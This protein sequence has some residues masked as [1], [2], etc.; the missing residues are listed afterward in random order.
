MHCFDHVDLTIVAIIKRT[1]SSV[2]TFYV[3]LILILLFLTIILILIF[4]GKVLIIGGG[5][6]NFTNVAATF[7]VS[8]AVY[9]QLFN[10]WLLISNMFWNL[11]YPNAGWPVTTLWKKIFEFQTSS[12]NPWKS[13]DLSDNFER[14]PKSPWI[15]RLVKCSWLE[16]LNLKLVIICCIYFHKPEPLCGILTYV[17]VEFNVLENHGKI[18]E[19]SLNFFMM[20][21]CMVMS[22]NIWC[23]TWDLKYAMLKSAAQYTGNIALLCS[24]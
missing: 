16:S 10:S 5:I 22:T 24:M 21:L 20:T 18:L 13:L 3:K 15:L 23:S 2:E 4:L 8:V 12:W 1:F 19:I 6:A 14:S 17:P 9:I 11:F 7:K